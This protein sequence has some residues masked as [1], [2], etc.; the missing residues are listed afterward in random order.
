[1]IQKTKIKLKYHKL[2]ILM[3][4]L[5]GLSACYEHNEF[6]IEPS[7]SFIGMN[8][9]SIAQGFSREDSITIFL[10]LRDG[11][12]DIGFSNQD[13]M[14]NSLYITDLRT[15]NISEQFNIPEIPENLTLNGIEA[16]LELK[17]YTTCCL[18]PDN[19]PPCSVIGGYPV[20]T[21]VYEIVIKDRAGHTSEPVQ[22]P[23]IYILCR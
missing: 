8:K 23:P 6:P 5:T 20:D 11:D 10:T 21:I 19:I 13:S 16:E 18:F 17:L 1:M 9:D 7:L 4:F 22:T 14:L 15:G 2:L 12:G 3:V